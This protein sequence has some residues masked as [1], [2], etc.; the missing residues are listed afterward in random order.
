AHCRHLPR[1]RARRRGAPAPR[2]LPLRRTMNPHDV[3]AHLD[4]KHGVFVTG[5]G[6]G[7][8]SMFEVHDPATREVIAEISE[9]TASEATSA[10]EAAARAFAEWAATA[11]RVPAEIPR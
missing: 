6:L 8:A 11:P 5:R 10:V 1:R 7:T 4:P 3:I 9:G 2:P